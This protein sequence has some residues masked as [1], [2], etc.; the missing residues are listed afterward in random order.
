[1]HIWVKKYR[2]ICIIIKREKKDKKIMLERRREGK[3]D[4][5]FRVDVVV[6]NNERERLVMVVK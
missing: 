3:Y 4:K 2:I 6:R 1:M 5:G